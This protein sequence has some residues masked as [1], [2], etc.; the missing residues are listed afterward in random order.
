[1]AQWW[2]TLTFSVLLLV[3]ALC[4]AEKIACTT[5]TSNARIRDPHDCARYFMCV[6]GV[7]QEMPPCP[8]GTVWSQVYQTCVWRGS[9]G[10]DCSQSRSEDPPDH[11]DDHS[12][13]DHPHG[14]WWEDGEDERRHGPAKRPSTR[15]PSRFRVTYHQPAE[16]VQP[17][18]TRTWWNDFDMDS[19]TQMSPEWWGKES[20]T[21]V[22]WWRSRGE[23]R[24]TADIAWWESTVST[25]PPGW[26]QPEETNPPASWKKLTDG[27]SYW[28]DQTDAPWRYQKIT[29]RPEW[30]WEGITEQ[31]ESHWNWKGTTEA[32]KPHEWR[33]EEKTEVPSYWDKTTAVP[34]LHWW[35]K[36]LAP[37]KERPSSASS[38]SRGGSAKGKYHDEV[39]KLA[40]Y[41]IILLQICFYGTKEQVKI[42]EKLFI[43]QEQR[44][45]TQ[46][47]E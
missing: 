29:E 9:A 8:E 21:P 46:K 25:G 22:P 10:D 3:N 35:D 23:R 33:W 44:A 5:A 26:W 43:S 38:W 14:A 36:T 28:E 16:R 31:T 47:M 39:V 7:A 2:R 41:K 12:D 40:L 11:H 30:N 45:N 32:T 6:L 42:Y 27:P 24:T 13:H 37:T 19:T 15:P 1:M 4:A 20:V 18:S 34:T 17:I